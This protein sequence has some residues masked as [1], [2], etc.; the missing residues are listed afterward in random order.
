MEIITDDPDLGW[1]LTD[2]MMM[3]ALEID[4]KALKLPDTIA[5]TPDIQSW[6]NDCE[7]IIDT[8]LKKVDDAKR[9]I[10]EILTREKKGDSMDA[11][12]NLEPG[13]AAYIGGERRADKPMTLKRHKQIVDASYKIKALMDKELGPIQS[14]ELCMLGEIMRNIGELK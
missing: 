9:G 8:E 2:K 10:F 3:E 14:N 13:S 4:L 12:R 5:V 11:M 7:S 6:L 1:A